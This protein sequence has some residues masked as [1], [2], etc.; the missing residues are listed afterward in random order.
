[1][2]E[3][4]HRNDA[5]PEQPRKINAF[6]EGEKYW[7]K[8]KGDRVALPNHAKGSIP[9]REYSLTR[10]AECKRNELGVGDGEP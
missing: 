7:N 3:A 5:G 9:R 6:N 10:R 2:R 4:S 1:M 8:G